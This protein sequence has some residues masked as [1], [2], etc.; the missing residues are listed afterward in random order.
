MPIKNSQ[1]INPDPFVMNEDE[2]NCHVKSFLEKCDFT[3]VVALRGNQPGEDVSGYK[4]GWKVTVESKGSHANKHSDEIVF[5]DDQLWDHLCKQIGKLMEYRNRGISNSLLV[6]ANPDIPRIHKHLN[7]VI[8][9]LN[10]LEIIRFWIDQN[11][12]ITVD[13]PTN[14]KPI[15][16]KL[17]LIE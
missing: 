5:K 3:N 16:K 12:E 8:S 11:G 7:K 14:L 2:I 17:S 1:L 13:Y 6:A 15:L 4:E 9:S 10:D